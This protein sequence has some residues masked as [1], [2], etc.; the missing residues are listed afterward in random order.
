MWSGTNSKDLKILNRILVR[1]IIRRRGPISRSEIAQETGLTPSTVTVITAE[2]LEAGVIKEAGH[3]EST[4]GRRPV[5]LELNPTAAHIFAVKLQR[6]EATAALFGLTCNLL[7]ERTYHL[8]TDA[9]EGVVETIGRSFQELAREADIDPGSVLLC[10]VACP[11]LV[12][13]ERGI[14][15]RSSNLGWLKVP[16]GEM[17]RNRLGGISVHV[18][19]ISN[20]AALAEKEFG[21]GKGYSDMVFVNLS[22]GVSAGILVNGEIYGG[23]QGY[24]GEI[25]HVS[26]IPKDGPWCACGRRGCFEAVCGARAVLERIKARVPEEE[27]ARYGLSKDLVKLNELIGSPLVDSPEVQRVVDETGRAVGILVANLVNLLNPRIII[28]GGEL[29]AFGKPLLRAVEE[30][31]KLRS[32]EEMYNSTSI[33]LSN[34]RGSGPLMGVYALALEKVFSL[35]E[36]DVNVE[37]RV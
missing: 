8:D 2:L 3:G 23:V 17:I 25:G 10:G 36:W 34:L 16:L 27:F 22:V 32:L 33:E 11:G 6:G 35:E 19:N 18:E 26:F 30:E 13:S 7:A 9:P 24:A 1:N 5:L 20:A 28:L 37:L 14:V 4:G 29:S 15:E 12:C 21:L 31:V